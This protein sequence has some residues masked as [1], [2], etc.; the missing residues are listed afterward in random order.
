[1][2]P[3]RVIE[4]NA[5]LKRALER[6]TKIISEP[7]VNDY[8]LDALI[9]RFEFTYEVAWKTMKAWLE[10]K[11]I[12]AGTPR[13]CFREAFAAGLLRHG[14]EWM[15]MMEDRN[16]SSHTYDE[17]QVKQIAGRIATIHM[18]NLLALSQAIEEDLKC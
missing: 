3:E 10:Y 16:I 6:L 5:N 12:N 4:K 8:W 13:D 2:T 14:E 9:Q 7:V 18:D 17:E 15:L 11:G 1:M